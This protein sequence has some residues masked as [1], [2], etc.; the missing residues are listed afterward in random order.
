MVLAKGNTP[1]LWLIDHVPE[2]SRMDTRLEAW[3]W[4]T[5]YL[6]YSRRNSRVCYTTLL[7][8]RCKSSLKLATPLFNP[9]TYELCTCVYWWV[10]LEKS[11]SNAF[12]GISDNTWFHPPSWF[13]ISA[14]ALAYF[15]L[16]NF[17]PALP[18]WSVALLLFGLIRSDHFGKL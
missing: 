16:S 1:S 4:Y 8:L 15:S 7:D 14:H 12:F 2:K 11:V 5:Y 6:E 10:V 3:F 13:F 9:I 17:S 18:D